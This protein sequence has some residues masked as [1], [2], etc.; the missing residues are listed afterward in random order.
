MLATGRSS[1]LPTSLQHCRRHSAFLFRQ[2][3]LVFWLARTLFPEKALVEFLC[4]ILTA[5]IFVS[6]SYTLFPDPDSS[7]LL[8][9]SVTCGNCGFLFWKSTIELFSSFFY[10]RFFP[11]G[12]HFLLFL[13]SFFTS[14]CLGLDM[15]TVP[16][17]CDLSFDFSC[18]LCRILLLI[19][20]KFLALKNSILSSILLS[21]R[22]NLYM[23]F[24]NFTDPQYAYSLLCLFLTI[25]SSILTPPPLLPHPFYFLYPV[26]LLPVFA[27]VQHC[28]PYNCS[29]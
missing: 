22:P 27:S 2:Y 12:R 9:T 29:V 23:Y 13:F 24:S 5:S 8:W 20:S 10:H 11:C 1:L 4:H 16:S 18:G 3:S 26:V 14:S 6:V 19:I 25:Q 28:L 21:T 17:I 7:R 15:S